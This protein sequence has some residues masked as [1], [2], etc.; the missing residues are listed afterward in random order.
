MEHEIYKAAILIS[1]N[2]QTYLFLPLLISAPHYLYLVIAKTLIMSL[3]L[4][5]DTHYTVL[6]VYYIIDY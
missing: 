1:S 3:L 4:Y 6:D 2:T 5:A